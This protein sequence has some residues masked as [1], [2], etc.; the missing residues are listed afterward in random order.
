MAG[1]GGQQY[2]FDMPG[3]ASN[4]LAQIIKSQYANYNA[5][6]VPEENKQIAFATDPN[7]IPNAQRR[8]MAT[9]EGAFQGEQAGIN[10]SLE[11]K[12]IHLTPDQQASVG[13]R[14]QVNQAMAVS[15]AANRSGARTYDTVSSILAGSPSAAGIVGA[16]S[17]GGGAGTGIP[18][19]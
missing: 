19:G 17:S 18:G 7:T 3:S 6:F 13:R 8:A 12:G 9:T 16:A 15:D 5:M 1:Q 14:N 11:A 10:K 4:I 2:A